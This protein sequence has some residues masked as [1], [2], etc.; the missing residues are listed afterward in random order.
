MSIRILHCLFV[1]IQLGAFL[2]SGS[3]LKESPLVVVQ[4]NERTHEQ[5]LPFFVSISTTQADITTPLPTVPTT[6][7]ST[8]TQTIPVVNPAVSNPD[9][10]GG[11]TTTTPVM[12][13]ATTSP[14]SSGG[15]WCVA[16]QSASQTALQGALDYACGYG[17]AD[18]SAIQPSGGCYQ[19][20]TIRDH[21]SYAFNSYYQKNP[22]P[23]SCNFGGTAVITS[24]DP[25]N[26]TC[27]YQSTST[28]SSVLNTTNSSGS[29]VFGAGPSN[30]TG[31]AAA[32]PSP[33]F[34]IFT[35]LMMLVLAKNHAYYTMTSL[36]LFRNWLN[37]FLVC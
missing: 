1:F 3:S 29:T 10:P 9:S 17:G 21:A 12:T 2:C 11:A 32:K 25:S 33:G 20:N 22:V 27:Q 30:P 26:G 34:L 36:F 6:N 14:A 8:P 5:E 35:L 28:S 31:S 15:S 37:I 13:P 19:P 18:C 23:N 24:T 7:P 16:S 4:S